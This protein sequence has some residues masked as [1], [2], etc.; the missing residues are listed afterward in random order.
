[1]EENNL[2]DIPFEDKII[3]CADCEADLL[4]MVKV[5][6]SDNK[7]SISATCPLCDGSS[8]TIDLSGKY[9][10]AASDGFLVRDITEQ[11]IKFVVEMIKDER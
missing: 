8:W 7:F 11:D 1:M 5:A 3:K 6:D 2:E 10:Q 4:K 9:Y